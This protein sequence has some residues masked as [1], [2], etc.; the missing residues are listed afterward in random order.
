V[1]KEVFDSLPAMWSENAKHAF[2]LVGEEG[3][4]SLGKEGGRMRKYFWIAVMAATIIAVQHWYGP[5]GG[6]RLFGA[7]F[8]LSSVYYIFVRELPFHLGQHHVATLTGWKKAFV[9]LP[10]FCIG[11]LMIYYGAEITCA[12]AKYKHLCN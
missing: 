1:I 3:V 2:V 12:P 9:I 11:F 10:V 4:E 5:I 8:L 7:F 6:T